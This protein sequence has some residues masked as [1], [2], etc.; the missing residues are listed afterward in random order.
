MFHSC[1]IRWLLHSGHNVVGLDTLPSSPH[2]DTLPT[3]PHNIAVSLDTVP[4]SPNIVVSLD[5]LPSSPHLD[6]LPTSPLLPRI[7]HTG[8][9]YTAS[10]S[11]DYKNR[12]TL[13]VYPVHYISPSSKRGETFSVTWVSRQHPSAS[14][15]ASKGFCSWLRKN[16]DLGFSS[17]HRLFK[18]S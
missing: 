10:R 3:S 15:C 9:Y 16:L 14:V 17:V 5:T 7:Q 11:R 4:S 18:C 2:L 1:I 8:R 6:T 13:I 12:F